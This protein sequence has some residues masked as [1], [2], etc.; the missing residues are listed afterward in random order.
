MNIDFQDI[1]SDFFYKISLL[2]PNII[3]AIVVLIIAII[4]GKVVFKIIEK[5]TNKKWK[6]SIISSFLAQIIKWTF[7]L[8][9]V[10]IALNFLGFTG[11][12]NTLFAGAG[13]S[14]IV[15]GFAFKDIGENFLSGIILALKRPFEIGDII[16]IQGDKGTVKALDLRLT[17]IRNPEG[18]DI[19]IPNS[20]IIKN[21]LTNYTKDGLLRINFMIGIAPECDIEKTRKLILDYLKTNKNILKNP[22]HNVVVQEL[23]EYTTDIQVF[24][25]INILSVKNLPDEYLGH[26][27]RSKVITD[28][29]TILDKNN[30]EMPS[31]VIE[32]KMYRQNKILIE[33]N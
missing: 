5:A 10:V 23:G 26:S 29:K 28:I 16:E 13:V 8:F 21:T 15:I 33:D 1:F 11:I 25:W 20:T 14:A 19:Y 30:I 18:K 2:L 24:F 17:H 4:A 3:S 31:Q 9:G 32:H 12:A 27:I 7:Y 6:D 22:E